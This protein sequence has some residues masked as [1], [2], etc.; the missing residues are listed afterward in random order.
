MS[1][2]DNNGTIENLEDE[3]EEESK[4]RVL[5]GSDVKDWEFTTDLMKTYVHGVEDL[6]VMAGL[7]S[8]TR[9]SRRRGAA[10]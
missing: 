1:I 5:S 6:P 8:W 7:V 10:Y 9:P 2:L 3:F 4:G